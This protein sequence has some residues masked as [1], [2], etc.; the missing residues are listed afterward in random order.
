MKLGLVSNQNGLGVDL[1]VN[2][3]GIVLETTLQSVILISLLS[4]GRANSDDLPDD[5]GSGNLWSVDRRGWCGDSILT[6]QNRQ[7][8][9]SRLWL[10]SRAKKSEETRRKA[11]EYAHQSLQWLLDK[12]HILSLDIQAAWQD[13]SGYLLLN[14]DVQPN[15]ASPLSYSF[16]FKDGGLYAL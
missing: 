9:G 8:I 5:R 1:M 2:N 3:Q 14:I 10:L 15:G 11:I 6:D 4:D 13:G 16:A 7:K 12:G